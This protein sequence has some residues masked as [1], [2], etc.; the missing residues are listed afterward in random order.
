MTREWVRKACVFVLGFAHVKHADKSRFLIEDAREY[1][2]ASGFLA[3]PDKRAW[4]QVPTALRRRGELRADGYLPSPASNGS[5]KV[6][7]RLVY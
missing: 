6:A 4:G 3:P 5:P 2:E 1:A 7:W